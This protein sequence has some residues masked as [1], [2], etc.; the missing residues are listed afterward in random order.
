[1]KDIYPSPLTGR[2][3][4]SPEPGLDLGTPIIRKTNHYHRFQSRTPFRRGYCC[5]EYFATAHKSNFLFA[6]IRPP[7]NTAPPPHTLTR[8]RVYCYE[9]FAKPQKKFLFLLP[10]PTRTGFKHPHP[11]V[12]FIVVTNTSQNHKRNSL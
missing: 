5:Y 11:S 8:R 12:V 1:M 4:K 10:H 9:Y 3:A 7:I 6:H 2:N